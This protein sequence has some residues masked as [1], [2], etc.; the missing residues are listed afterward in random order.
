MPVATISPPTRTLGMEARS[1]NSVSIELPLC[2]LWSQ[3]P[4]SSSLPRAQITAE[5]IAAGVTG[6]GEQHE[7]DPGEDRVDAEPFAQPAGYA[8]D[9]AVAAA[10]GERQ[11][12]EPQPAAGR[13][14][15]VRRPGGRRL[16]LWCAGLTRL[17]APRRL[18]RALGQP[19]GR[20]G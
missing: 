6:D 5:P 11:C 3:R 9:D 15:R 13:Q 10:A 4:R 14:P 19:P 1:P 8:G 17:P 18:R 16:P 7:R 2:A 12:V 20:S